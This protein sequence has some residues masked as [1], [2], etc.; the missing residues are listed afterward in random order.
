MYRGRRVCRDH[1]L[2]L[3]RLVSCGVNLRIEVRTLTRFGYGRKTSTLACAISSVTTGK[4]Y[5]HLLMF[6]E[7]KDDIPE[8]F[9]VHF[10]LCL[11][12]VCGRCYSRRSIRIRRNRGSAL[13]A[14]GIFRRP[15]PDTRVP[16]FLEQRGGGLNF[17]KFLTESLRGEFELCLLQTGAQRSNSHLIVAP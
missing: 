13:R 7:L 11:R 9:E 16:L 6:Q 17:S 4:T 2:R 15:I 8:I 14:V 10:L 1:R 5:S 3:S 12:L